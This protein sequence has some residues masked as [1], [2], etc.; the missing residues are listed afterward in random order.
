MYLVGCTGS[1]KSTFVHRMLKNLEGM[2]SGDPPKE[3][4][5]CYGIYQPIFETMEQE[6][7]N[8]TL[9]QGIPSQTDI[10]DFT[11]EDIHKLIILDDCM[12]LVNRDDNMEQLFTQ[13]CH[14][15]RIS[16][17]F[18]SQNMFEK[19]KNSRTISLNTWYM[20]LFKNIRGTSQIA[21]LGQQCFPNQR[22]MLTEVYQDC[23]KEKYGYLFLD[24]APCAPETYRLRTH[25]FP[26]EYPI[27]YLPKKL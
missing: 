3:I 15:R 18:L 11:K 10:D 22:G 9:H 23:M 20:V 6:I 5:L 4:L 16:I 2:Y 24:L 1:G 25:V 8:L 17:W 19:G 21:A 13:G 7:P 14:H 27:I 12:K 26:N